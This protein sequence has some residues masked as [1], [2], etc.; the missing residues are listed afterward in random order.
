MLGVMLYLTVLTA[1]E[2]PKVFLKVT[3]A[4]L[5]LNAV[6]NFAFMNGFGPVPAFGPTG[7]GLSSLLVASTS[8][9]ILFVIARRTIEGERSRQAGIR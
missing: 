8:L 7:A 3:I 1:A 2:K 6:G 4:M 9:G 5:P